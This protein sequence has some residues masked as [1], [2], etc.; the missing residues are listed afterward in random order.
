VPRFDA[1]VLDTAQTIRAE[2]VA[3][4]IRRGPNHSRP[5]DEADFFCI[6]LRGSDAAIVAMPPNYVGFRESALAQQPSDGVTI[7]LLSAWK[8]FLGRLR[9]PLLFMKGGGTYRVAIVVV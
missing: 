9:A 6:F 3:L 1:R 2:G 8:G 5:L 4:L 7:A